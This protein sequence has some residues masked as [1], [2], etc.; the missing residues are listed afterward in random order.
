MQV[1][2]AKICHWVRGNICFLLCYPIDNSILQ[3]AQCFLQAVLA[4]QAAVCRQVNTSLKSSLSYK[5]ITLRHDALWFRGNFQPR[6]LYLIMAW[7]SPT[8]QVST[9]V[10]ASCCTVVGVSLF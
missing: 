10:V 5:V 9:P 6:K 2:K 1:L 4:G 7:L 3:K 8:V